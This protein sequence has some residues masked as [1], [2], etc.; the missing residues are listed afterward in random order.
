MF[1]W[2]DEDVLGLGCLLFLFCFVFLLLFLFLASAFTGHFNT[3]QKMKF[4]IFLYSV[5]SSDN[6]DFL[7]DD[8][9][10][11]AVLLKFLLKFILLV[12]FMKDTCV[13]KF[14]FLWTLIS[15]EKLVGFWRLF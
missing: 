4:S 5:S 10:R 13:R 2:F 1:P 11:K 8:S 3:G 15:F 9:L 12:F 14:V 6:V 7:D